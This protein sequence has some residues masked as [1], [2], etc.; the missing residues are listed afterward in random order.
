MPLGF[1]KWY[2]E[3]ERSP[4][5]SSANTEEL[6]RYLF[7]F[8]TSLQ[9]AYALIEKVEAEQNALYSYQKY[10]ES[11]KVKRSRVPPP[12]ILL[13]RTHCSVTLKPAPFL[14]DV[15]VRRSPVCWPMPRLSALVT[16][17][18]LLTIV[19]K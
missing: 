3:R 9:E 10:L 15:K 14:S 11:T 1:K 2:R 12:P 8:H 4:Q 13:A 6:P 5:E 18:T 7:Y 17:M 16:T 19:S